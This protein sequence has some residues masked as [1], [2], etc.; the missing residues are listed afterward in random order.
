VELYRLDALETADGV[1]SQDFEGQDDGFLQGVGL[2]LEV[3][4]VNGGVIAGRC[5]EWIFR[6]VIDAGDS[7]FV[8]GHGLVRLV[9]EVEV[10]AE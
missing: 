7:F 5:H 8:E 3:E 4:D 2:S 9:A 6:M 10:E 1:A